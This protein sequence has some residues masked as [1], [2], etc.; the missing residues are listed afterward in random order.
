M[1]ANRSL[2][3]ELENIK[4]MNFKIYNVYNISNIGGEICLY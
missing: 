3:M 1:K 4:N 2:V